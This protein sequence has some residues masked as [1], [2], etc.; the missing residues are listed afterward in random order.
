MALQ[1]DVERWYG[2][3]LRSL[4][5]QRQGCVW[6][7]RAK[8]KRSG[9]LQRNSIATRRQSEVSRWRRFA[10][11]SRQSS[12]KVLHCTAKASLGFAMAQ[13]SNGKDTLSEAK[14]TD[15]KAWALQRY[16]RAKLGPVKHGAGN[17]MKSSARAKFS[18]E[19]R[20][21]RKAL[22]WQCDDKQCKGR[23]SPS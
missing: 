21:Y 1:S 9:T 22:R 6:H 12:G 23:V 8:A 5:K 7:S 2:A 11:Q 18:S 4:A 13:R 19:R 16:A 3:A 17:D 15:G 20:G 14:A 10:D